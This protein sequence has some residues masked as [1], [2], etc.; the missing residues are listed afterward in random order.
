KHERRTV[1]RRGRAADSG[2]SRPGGRQS[3]SGRRQIAAARHVNTSLITV[4]SGGIPMRLSARNQ[5]QGKVKRIVVGAVNS[6]VTVELAGGDE[7]VAIITRASVERLGLAEGAAAI[8][9]I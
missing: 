1:D 9:V 7:V 5:L 3:P 6:E 4:P 2:V 8:V